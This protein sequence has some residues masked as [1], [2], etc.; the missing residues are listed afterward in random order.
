MQ[1]RL[2]GLDVGSVRVG[3]ALSCPLGMFASPVEVIDRRQTSPFV[4]LVELI[5]EHGVRSLVV[6]RPTR[7]NGER[8]PAVIAIEAFVQE[9]QQHT[10][11]PVIWW[12]ERLSTAQAQRTLIAHNVRRNKR[13][14][15]IDK[16]A[17]AL[18]L[19]SYMDAQSSGL[20]PPEECTP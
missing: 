14:E 13:R 4:R 2:L 5:A 15:T 20:L 16:V 1:G 8:G 18:I 6:G 9:L 17:A 19:Q 10:A 7:L 11:V 3:V 12:D